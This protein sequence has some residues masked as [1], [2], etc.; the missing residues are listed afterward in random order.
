[1]HPATAMFV[2]A[3]PDDESLWTGGTTARLVDA[4]VCVSVVCCTW[5]EGTPRHTELQRAVAVL[6]TPPAVALGYADG[7]FPESA[8]GAP[9]LVD[10]HLEEQVARV[11]TQ[12]RRQRPDVVVTYDAY[13]IYGHPDHI[14][15]HRVT[16]AAVEAA[17]TSS[18]YPEAGPAWAVASI[19]LAT[20]PLSVMERIGPHI[21]GGEG[22]PRGTPDA[23]VDDVVDVR[24]WVDRKWA[25]IGEHRSELDRSTA[26]R[27][28]RATDDATRRRLLGTEY[29]LRRDLVPGGCPLLPDRPDPSAG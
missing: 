7:G 12:I 23:Q 1:M 20:M 29:F 3:H 10:A 19:Y 16:L 5:A 13:G 15:T 17:A 14:H 26:L 8:P 6:G 11:A 2:H 18:L 4:G 27:T 25:A 22:P 28:L 21:G 9:R 24:P